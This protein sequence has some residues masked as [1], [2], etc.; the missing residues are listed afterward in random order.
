M[1]GHTVWHT[2]PTL[3]KLLANAKIQQFPT[4]PYLPCNYPVCAGPKRAGLS[5]K[6]R[7]LRGKG[8]RVC[9]NV[10]S[11]MCAN[12]QLNTAFVLHPTFVGLQTVPAGRAGPARKKSIISCAKS[13][14][15]AVNV[16]PQV[17]V[18]IR[19]PN[20]QPGPRAGSGRQNFE[21]CTGRAELKLF[22]K[23]RHFNPKLSLKKFC[24]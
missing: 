23:D 5:P 6:F 14:S 21:S 4:A 20:F 1:L 19:T 3:S 7:F 18:L 9:Q 24:F 15:I 11:T 17:F 13:A 2:L 10:I 22:W 16:A 12:F 8:I